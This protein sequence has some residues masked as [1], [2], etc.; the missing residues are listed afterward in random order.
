MLSNCGVGED[1]PV[2]P[3]GN[4]PWIFIG[5]TNAEAEAV[6]LWPPDG[7]S[8]LIRKNLIW[9]GLKAEGDDRGQDGWMAS[10]TQ[11]TWVWTN[12]RRWSRT[13]KLGMLKSMGVAKNGAQLS[14][15]TTNSIIQGFPGHSYKESAGWCRRYRRYG[16]GL[17]VG[18][19]SWRRKW[20][21]TPVFLPGKLHGQRNLAGYSPQGCKESDTT[22][23]KHNSILHGLFNLPIEKPWTVSDS[24]KLSDSHSVMSNSLQ[25][26]GL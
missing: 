14:D 8:W 23:H 4:Q 5:R 16:F 11:W 12:S 1:Q 9:D 13:G 25:P 26:H 21:P 17:L 3:K 2:Y 20:Q 22:E 19:I 6:I 18:K 10:L 7:K 15:W 24:Q